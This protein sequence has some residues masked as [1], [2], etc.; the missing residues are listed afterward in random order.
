MTESNPHEL[1]WP[2]SKS[3]NMRRRTLKFV[4]ALALCAFGLPS[5]AEHF[6][7]RWHVRQEVKELNQIIDRLGPDFRNV[8]ARASTH[9]EAWVFGEL[10]SEKR[11]RLYEA[12]RDRFGDQEAQRIVS[13]VRFTGPSTQ[14]NG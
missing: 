14:R 6:I 1:G 3:G 13:L 9:P 4:F 11:V 7:I 10:T 5:V 8:H 2:S 12:V